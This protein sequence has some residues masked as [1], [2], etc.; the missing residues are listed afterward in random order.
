ME[1]DTYG[2]DPIPA[3]LLTL[4]PPGMKLSQGK[5]AESASARIWQLRTVKFFVAAAVTLII[6]LGAF[7][8]RF[9]MPVTAFIF[10]LTIVVSAVRLGFWEATGASII[11]VGSLD[12]FFTRPLFSF[13]TDATGWTAL[14]AFE[15]TALVVSRL[16][17]QVQRQAKIADQQRTNMEHLYE[18]ARRILLVDRREPVGPQIAA[19]I[20]QALQVGPVGLFDAASSRVYIAGSHGD[21]FEQ[22]V[23]NAWISGKGE[24]NRLG[25]IWSRVLLLDRKTIGAIAIRAVDLSPIVVD[26]VASIA[27]IAVER[28][29]S[30]E[31]ETRAEA[32]R[33][34]EQ[35]R[36]AVLDALAHAFKTPLTT[37]LAASSGLLESGKLRTSEAELVQLIDDQSVLLNDLTT[38]MLQTA[39]LDGA[40]IH[41]Q[42][43]ESSLAELFEELLAL[44]QEQLAQ[45]PA[46]TVLPQNDVPVS[47]DRGLIVMALRQLVDNAIKYSNPGSAITLS[48]EIARDALVISVHNEGIPIPAE[49]RERIF[50]RFYRSP[51]TKHRAAGTGLGLSITKK[52]AEAHHGSVWVRSDERGTTFYLSLPRSFRNGGV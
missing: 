52:I 4:R 3:A 5:M 36:T 6:G 26:A 32:A 50:E 39:R 45:R 14:L 30:I 18:L 12:Y 17:A 13:R 34:S 22:E 33:Q 46:R 21:G 35:L 9:S 25:H 48:G 49:D 16:S 1:L 15:C 19:Y 47:G 28:S 44:F 29:H 41:L 8:L 31:K 24:D 2:R 37:I 43:E 20:Q 11:A 42:H 40:A 23:R 7:L 38:R 51:G 10:F 27:A